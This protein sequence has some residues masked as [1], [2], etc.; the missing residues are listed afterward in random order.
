MA[1]APAK[2]PWESTEASVENTDATSEQPADE[3]VAAE[4]TVETQPTE[5]TQDEANE[6]DTVVIDEVASE[7]KT[8]V[9]STDEASDVAAADEDTGEASSDEDNGPLIEEAISGELLDMVI[10]IVPKQFTLNID[11][12]KTF[13]YK[14]GTQ[15]MERAHAEH[16]WAVANGVTLFEG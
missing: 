4:T 3:A 16:W 1:K 9:E 15:R 12:F 6:I 7:E 13:T 14:A 5:Q 10:A 8:E 11:H 2:K